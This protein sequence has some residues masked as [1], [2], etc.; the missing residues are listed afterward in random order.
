MYNKLKI[1]K[2][3]PTNKLD[4]LFDERVTDWIEDG[5]NLNYQRQKHREQYRATICKKCTKEQKEKR[6]C[7]VVDYKSNKRSCGHMERAVLQK[8]LE[9]AKIHTVS[10]PYN[11]RINNIHIEKNNQHSNG[12]SSPYK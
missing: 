3:K 12:R 9:K 2:S 7:I 5:L 11:L 6:R 1:I 4:E 8:F 10:H